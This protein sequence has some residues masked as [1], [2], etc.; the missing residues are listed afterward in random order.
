[1]P[2]KDITDMEKIVIAGILVLGREYL[3]TAFRMCHNCKTSNEQSISVMQSRWWASKRLSEFKEKVKDLLCG[4]S[5][6]G[7]N[8]L[9]TRDG[10]V[11]QLISATKQTKG[12]D[13]I[14]GLQT[15]AKMQGYDKP[16]E[17]SEGKEQRTYFLPW[18]SVCRTCE[19]MKLYQKIIE[20]QNKQNEK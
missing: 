14:S 19:L 11:N 7:G 16:I 9:K 13:S 3:P 2:K 1:M 4:N 17:E 6:G 10:I 5:I 20:G 12:K 18:V 8:D 15:L